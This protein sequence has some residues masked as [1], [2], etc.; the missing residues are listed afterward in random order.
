MTSGGPPAS[1]PH[2]FRPPS[3]DVGRSPPPELQSPGGASF[4]R[5]LVATILG[6]LLA[7]GILLV[8]GIVLT[9]LLSPEDFGRAA[10]ATVA[11]AMVAGLNFGIGWFL[12]RRRSNP[13]GSE[14]VLDT[15][16]TLRA[17]RGFALGGGVVAVSWGLV[18]SYEEPAL[19]PIM[20][21][22]GAAVAL[23]GLLST[24][25][26]EHQR[27][28]RFERTISIDLIALFAG[29]GA[30]IAVAPVLGSQAFGAA[31]V[32]RVAVRVLLSHVA[33]SGHSNRPRWSM[34]V[35]REWWAFGRWVIAAA[36]LA[37]VSSRVGPIV[38]GF[39]GWSPSQPRWELLSPWNVSPMLTLL[40]ATFV[41]VG[42]RGAAPEVSFVVLRR[43]PMMLGATAAAWLALASSASSPVPEAA[44]AALAGW[45]STVAMTYFARALADDH[46]KS[47]AAAYAGGCAWGIGWFAMRGAALELATVMM[48][49]TPLPIALVAVATSR[50]RA[51]REDARLT[52]LFLLTLG[53]ALAM[54]HVLGGVVPFVAVVVGGLA[55]APWLLAAI[56][57]VRRWRR[58][59]GPSVLFG[60]GRTQGGCLG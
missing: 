12:I 48:T 55:S 14:E 38:A 31:V 7:R 9:R 44:A 45:A 1:E 39:G 8:E 56:V 42:A 23:D 11:T 40:L 21:L 51:L 49:L 4:G 24:R 5:S 32:A 33:L 36:M 3:A 47:I 57:E 20:L 50:T 16:W 28:L 25:W 29:A 53:I 58:G 52:G 34:P 18:A 13:A 43:I 6:P 59:L 17:L 54:R 15:A 60:A 2:L 46:P 37:G 27:E 22:L 10:I 30:G 41:V 19:R 35:V 26:F